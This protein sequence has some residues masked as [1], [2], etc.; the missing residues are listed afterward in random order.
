MT[1]RAAKLN[2]TDV[3][4]AVRRVLA[5]EKD[6]YE[7]IHDCCDRPLRAFVGRRY[8]WAGPDFA[9][10]VAVRTHECA[11]RRLG[12]FDPD[13]ATLLTWLCWQARGVARL[14]LAERYGPRLVQFDESRH[15]RWAQ[16]LPGPEARHE[17]RERNRM[18]WEV[19]GVL[20]EECR[21]V[22]EL[23]DLMGHTLEQTARLTGMHVSRVWRLRQRGLAVMKRRLQE[24]GVSPVERDSTPQ[25]V[26]Y[27]RDDTGYDDDWTATVTA[28]LPDGPGTLFG[29]DAREPKE[30]P[31]VAE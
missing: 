12:S 22:I 31:N 20:P 16:A 8:Y 17:A 27:G 19:F 18:L 10:E 9:D 7:T 28:N 14:V 1:D 24:L 2:R 11:L 26:W 21:T 13:K 30:G 25:P 29:A 3:L 23:H 4:A 15:E 6:A 5:G